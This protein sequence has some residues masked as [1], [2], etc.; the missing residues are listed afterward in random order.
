MNLQYRYTLSLNLSKISILGFFF[1]RKLATWSASS[2][3]CFPCSLKVYSYL[4]VLL[5]SWREKALKLGKWVLLLTN[6]WE[7]VLLWCFSSSSESLKIKLKMCLLFLS[8]L[9]CL[10]T[11]LSSLGLSPSL[12]F[13]FCFCLKRTLLF[14]GFTL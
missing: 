12:T 13:S 8:F 14:G 2:K 4:Q 7:K 9:S 10:Y 1:F 5:L 3:I 11:G 6:F